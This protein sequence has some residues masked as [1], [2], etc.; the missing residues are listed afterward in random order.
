MCTVHDE[1]F[2]LISAVKCLGFYKRSF[3]FFFIFLEL[4]AFVNSL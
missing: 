3:F 1:E 4:I 2:P